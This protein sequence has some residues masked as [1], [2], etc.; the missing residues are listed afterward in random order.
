MVVPPFSKWSQVCKHPAGITS[1]PDVRMHIEYWRA[2]RGTLAAYLMSIGLVPSVLYSIDQTSVATSILFNGRGRC[3][4][5]LLT[6]HFP[7]GP[8]Q[9]YDSIPASCVGD[10]CERN[11]WFVGNTIVSAS[12]LASISALDVRNSTGS[13]CPMR[14]KVLQT[15]TPDLP[16]KFQWRMSKSK[17]CSSTNPSAAMPS[18]GRDFFVI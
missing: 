6:N 7:T 12:T 11:S 15:S 17:T 18:T 9:A 14:R 16:G 8:S 10:Q 4:H 3:V 13:L 2:R 1:S 5:A